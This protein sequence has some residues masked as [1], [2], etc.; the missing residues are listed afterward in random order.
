MASSTLNELARAHPATTL[1][2]TY[3][4][5]VNTNLT[6]DMDTITHLGAK[7]LLSLASTG[8]E[9]LGLSNKGGSVDGEPDLR[10]YLLDRRVEKEQTFLNELEAFGCQ[11]IAVAVD[12]ANIEAV[13][14]AVSRCTK[15]LAGVINLALSLPVHS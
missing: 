2:L 15:P 13:K 4:G 1:F 11:V 3:P 7:A 9:Y 12:V 6:Q 5:V 14:A 10:A 8:I